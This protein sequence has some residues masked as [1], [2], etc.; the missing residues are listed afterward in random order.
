MA[1]RRALFHREKF[2]DDDL[3]ERVQAKLAEYRRTA[4]R[5]EFKISE[6]QLEEVEAAERKRNEE[7]EEVNWLG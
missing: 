1:F 6:P 7:V 2:S 5:A 3:A 4:G